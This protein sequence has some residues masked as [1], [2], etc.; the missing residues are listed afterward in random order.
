VRYWWP[1]PMDFSSTR[2]ARIPS[3]LGAGNVAISTSLSYR[4]AV[5][6]EMGTILGTLST[7]M[8]WARRLTYRLSRSVPCALVPSPGGVKV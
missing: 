3:S 5:S 6:A 4:R 2:I 1:L 8:N 7:G